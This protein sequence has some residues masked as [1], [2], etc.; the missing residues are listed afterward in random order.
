MPNYQNGKIYTIR[1]PDTEKYYLGSTTQALSERFR[2]HKRLQNTTAKQLFD[3]GI[4]QCYIELLENYQCN[5]VEELTK[6]EGELIR[7]HKDNLVNKIIVGRTKKEYHQDNKETIAEKQKIY[8]QTNKEILVEK[9]KIYHDNNKDTIYEKQKIYRDNI[10]DN[11][12]KD[13]KKIYY[14]NNKER[15]SEKTK[16]K[17]TCDC[18]SVVRISDKIRHEKTKKHQLFINQPTI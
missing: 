18:N 7:L 12:I 6:R 8:Y 10:D 3:L 15:I 16:P 2:G 5:S 17:F 4:D 9:Q 14:D 1:H 13:T 11:R